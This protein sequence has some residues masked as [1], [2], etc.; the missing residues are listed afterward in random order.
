MTNDELNIKDKA[1]QDII[2]VA[3]FKKEIRTTKPHKHNNYLEIIYLSQGHG[4]HTID[5]DTYIIKPPILFIVRKEQVHHWGLE[6]KPDGFVLLLRKTFVDKSLDR[7]LKAQLTKVSAI[8]YINVINTKFIEQVFQLLVEEANTNE[9]LS[10]TIIEGLLKSLLAKILQE[11]KPEIN[12]KKTKGNLF[13][14]YREI[15]SK[16][17]MLKNNV[18]YYASLLNTTPQNLNAICR[19]IA[20]QSASD[21]LS[22]FI[23]N[24]AKRLLIYTDMSVSEIALCLDFHDGSHFVKYFKRHTKLTPNSYRKTA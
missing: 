11:S 5:S 16:E 17:K 6:N 19:K 21:I 22:E 7:E 10:A 15:L 9:K 8:T 1:K 13:E 3:P 23:I 24:E 18:S 14:N 12:S 20:Q 2:K 4:Y